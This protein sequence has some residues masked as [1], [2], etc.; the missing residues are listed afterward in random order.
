MKCREGHL[1]TATINSI[2]ND[3][4]G[5]P[6]CSGKYRYSQN[7]RESQLNDKPHAMFVCWV[8]EYKNAESRAVMQCDKGH[9]WEA[10]VNSLLNGG[11]GCPSCAKYGFDPAKPGTLYALRSECGR[12]IKIGISNNFKR[13]VGEL[14]KR[15]PFR[16]NVVERFDSDGK[17][18]RRLEKAF[19][20]EF[21]SS[22]LEGFD[23]ATEWLEFTPDI[24]GLMRTLRV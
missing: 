13:R 24:L 11:T 15:T 22:G 3:S 21:E 6:K 4:A 1:W 17:T 20:V 12:L 16:F 18:I 23:G 9:V 19:H 10:S 2:L 7:E 14:T 8:N 5:C